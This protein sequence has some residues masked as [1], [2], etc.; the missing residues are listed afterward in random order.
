MGGLVQGI[1]G[2]SKQQATSGNQAYGT[3]ASDYGGQIQNGTDANNLLSSLLTG[4]AAG[5]QGLQSYKDSSGYQ[6]T[7][8]AGSQA[9]TGNNASRGLLN[10][11]ATGKALSNYGQQTNQSYYNNYLTNLL[12]L[13]S[14]G[15]TAGGL[16][17]S[18]GSTSQSTGNSNKGI[19]GLLGTVLGGLPG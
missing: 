7:L 5:A 13:S 18:A 15:T 3:L 2:G 8:D 12:G 19:S 9:I 14:A 10:S 1:F 17:A 6:S 16:L 4:G 11:G